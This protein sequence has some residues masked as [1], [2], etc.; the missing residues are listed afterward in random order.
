MKSLLLSPGKNYYFE[1]Y[2]TLTWQ[3]TFIQIIPL[4]TN[5]AI[6]KSITVP[7]VATTFI[8]NGTSFAMKVWWQYMV[9]IAIDVNID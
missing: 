9:F 8:V 6:W 4:L 5:R 2:M 1:K 3:H 7:N